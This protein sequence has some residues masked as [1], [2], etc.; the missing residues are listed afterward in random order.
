M[1]RY[2]N[3]Q[4]SPNVNEAGD[5]ESEQHIEHEIPP[6]D[7]HAGGGGFFGVERNGEEFFPEEVVSDADRDEQEEGLDDL[8]SGDHQQFADERA[9]QFFLAAGAPAQGEDGRG[10]G[11]DINNPDER[12]LGNPL[13]AG[14]GE[15][16]HDGADE[17]EAKRERVA[18]PVVDVVTD[19]HGHTGAEG[20]G[21][22]QREV[23]ENDSALNDV[24]A[25]INQQPGQ[26]QAGDQRP[27]HQQQQFVHI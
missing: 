12:F 26:R 11:D 16:E 1:T 9:L 6:A 8:R 7:V 14:P 13:V 17:G 24:Q 20:G 2:K 22:G 27:L 18:L 10:R 5:N 15:G 3:Q 25:K 4:D 19:D 21:L 23:D